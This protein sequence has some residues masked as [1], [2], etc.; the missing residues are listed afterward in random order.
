MAF[1]FF[2]HGLW[3]PVS[4]SFSY[5]YSFNRY[6]QT[7][8]AGSDTGLAAAEVEGVGD[9]QHPCTGMWDF[10]G[11]QRSLCLFMQSLIWILIQQ[12]LTG[13][14]QR[15][16]QKAI[17]LCTQTISVEHLASPYDC[18]LR[19]PALRPIPHPWPHSLLGSVPGVLVQ[20]REG[21]WWTIRAS[22]LWRPVSVSIHGSFPTEGVFS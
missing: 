19:P 14:L 21:E 1:S 7:V 12:I 10:M 6:S 3:F 22:S 13:K 2:L 11:W 15:G 18:R 20:T 17:H 9:R 8:Y 5:S 16:S 4:R